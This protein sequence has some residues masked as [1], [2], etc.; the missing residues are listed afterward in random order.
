MFLADYFA[1]RHPEMRQLM[2]AYAEWRYREMW[3]ILINK[4]YIYPVNRLNEKEM[5]L[6]TEYMKNK[7][8]RERKNNKFRFEIV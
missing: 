2:E 4:K 8:M 1:P 7:S 5:Y 3:E 6:F